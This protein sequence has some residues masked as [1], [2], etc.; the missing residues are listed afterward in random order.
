MNE[1]TVPKHLSASSQKWVK[2]V[3]EVF[4]LEDHHYHLLILAGETLDTSEAARKAIVKHG[5]TFE[6]K[7]GQPK[8]RPEVAIEANSK[9]LFRR[10]L[11]ELNL[12]EPIPEQR[13]PRMGGR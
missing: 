13:P 4:E 2:S 10:L 12:S 7:A 11:R 1:R 3:L 5:M 8:P 6:D 9:D